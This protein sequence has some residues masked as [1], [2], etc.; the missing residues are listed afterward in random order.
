MNL[1]ASVV[2]EGNIETWFE[3][4]TLTTEKERVLLSRSEQEDAY[5]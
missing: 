3:T 2:K 5:G 4:N 1:I